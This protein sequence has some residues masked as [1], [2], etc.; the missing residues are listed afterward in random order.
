MTHRDHDARRRR[1]GR[2]LVPAA[3]PP[4]RQG[5]VPRP[6]GGDGRGRRPAQGGGV[7]RPG[8]A[9]ADPLGERSSDDLG[10]SLHQLED[11]HR[12][13]GRSRDRDRRVPTAILCTPTR[14]RARRSTG[15]TRS[16][17]SRSRSPRWSPTTA[18]AAC[19]CASWWTAADV[20][21]TGF[22]TRA[23]RPS[24]PISGR[25][26]TRSGNVPTS[27]WT[28]S[29]HCSRRSAGTCSRS[30][31][32]R[33][34]PSSPACRPRASPGSGYS[35]HYFWDTEIYVLPFL[36]YTS[37]GMARSALRFRYNMLEA[38]RRRA[39]DLAQSGALFPWRT[40]NG[41]EASAYYA[42]GTAQYHIDAD[43]AFALCKYVQRDRRRATSCS[44]RASTSSSRPP[45][46]GPTSASGATAEPAT[47]SA[48][49]TSTASPGPDE[50]TTVVNDNLFTNVMARFNLAQAAR[51]VRELAQDAPQAYDRMVAPARSRSRRAR[52]VGGRR[53]GDDDPVR[54]GHRDQPAGLALPRP[55]DVGP[56][57]HPAREAPAAAAL[58]PAGD[59]PVPGAQAGRRGAR[60]VP[61]GQ[62]FQPASRSVPTSS[63]T[64]RSRPATRRCPAWSSRSSPR[65]S[66]TATSRCA[67]SYSS[68]F[69]D[70]ADLHGNAS[71]GVHVASTGGVWAA[72][73]YGFGGMRDYNGLIT[74]DPRLPASWPRLQFKITLRG[75]RLRVVV[76]AVAD[77]VHRRGRRRSH[78]R[79]TRAAGD[80]TRR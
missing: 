31:R 33:P 25:G 13:R 76:S 43:V 55:R 28:G 75:C 49:S 10:L 26:W 29:P 58:P 69:V 20:R 60:A 36:I 66:A 37:P 50:Y 72:L 79:R 67:T 48:R 17:G 74:F 39:A 22:A 1:A 23:S 14:T 63:T 30:P 73:V 35:G 21:S 70:L 62:P 6:V 15:S 61:A 32:P 64:T 65:R 41:E 8:A 52:R 80:R 57:A 27:S 9:A 5:R 38:A 51:V 7:R 3:Q 45:G 53:G 24:S 34:G 71:D 68:L 4:G 44:A 19:R 40:I 12:R 18:R 59:L 47:G 11:D 78:R 2:G 42:A 54:P 56:R 16:P 77:L 46:C